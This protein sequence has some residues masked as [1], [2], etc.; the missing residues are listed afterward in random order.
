MKKNKLL[1]IVAVFCFA[2]FG[3]TSVNAGYIPYEIDKVGNYL[4]DSTYFNG[5]STV[6]PDLRFSGN[7]QYTAIAFEAG[8]TNIT[9]N[10][11]GGSATENT[12]STGSTGNWGTWVDVNFDNANIFFSDIAD[13]PANVV[14]N[15]FLT[16]STFYFNLFQLSKDSN[17]LSYL[18]GNPKLILSA[19]TYIIGWND[20]LSDQ[21][22]DR[23]YDDI[24]VAMRPAPVP[25]P[26][27]MLLL[28]LGLVGLAG[29]ARRFKK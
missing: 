22:N 20:N 3:M 7:W 10:S 27:S 2:I 14:F 17:T 23:D 1:T 26:V 19:G 28:G 9:S 18:T 6:Q 25:E 21:N 15:P 16:T 11:T 4:S 5:Y 24:I 13:G 29:M 8:N 12:F